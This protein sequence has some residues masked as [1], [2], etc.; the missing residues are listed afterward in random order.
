[1]RKGTRIGVAAS[2]AA[3]GLGAAA[4]NGFGN[5]S[6]LVVTP[7]ANATLDGP[8]H[9]H[10]AGIEIETRGRRDT[11]IARLDFAKG[12]T[13]GWHT[14]PGPV[15]VAI[16]S[17]TLTLRHPNGHGGCAT[18]TFRPGTGF[19]EAGGDTHEATAVHGPVVVYATFLAWRGTKNY[20]VPVP[21]P[22]G[23]R[24]KAPAR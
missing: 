7:L 5:P 19:V 3:I 16:A 6:G 23:C 8:V 12:G 9:V 2:V 11:L 13:T 18:E 20:L 14:H 17:G 10:R 4:A 22:S 1:M 24:G 15:I 21:A